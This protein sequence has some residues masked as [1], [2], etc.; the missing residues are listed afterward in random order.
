MFG[1]EIVEQFNGPDWKY[2]ETEIDEIPIQDNSEDNEA[3]FLSS[4]LDHHPSQHSTKLNYSSREL[5][6]ITIDPGINN[7]VFAINKHGQ[8]VLSVTN[9]MWRRHTKKN[10]RE[11]IYKKAKNN[12]QEILN[13]ENKRRIEVCQL[14]F[15]FGFQYHVAFLCVNFCGCCVGCSKISL[16]KI[17]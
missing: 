9:A 12:N 13:L 11:K 3:T 10:E 7:V 5:E 4:E 15:S 14:V 16:K 8:P 6:E 2:V 1:K 17:I